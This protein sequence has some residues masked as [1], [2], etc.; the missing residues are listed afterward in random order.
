MKALLGRSRGRKI[1]SF[2]TEFGN[3]MSMEHKKTISNQKP[4]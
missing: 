1:K 4:K 3:T 2:Q